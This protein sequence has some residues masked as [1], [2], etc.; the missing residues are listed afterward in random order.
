[1]MC[2]GPGREARYLVSKFSNNIDLC[3]KAGNLMQPEWNE[4]KRFLEK[5]PNLSSRIRG[6]FSCDMTQLKFGGDETHK[7]NIVH[8]GYAINYLDNAPAIDFLQ[9]MIPG[10]I[11]LKDSIMPGVVIVKETTKQKEDKD[12]FD[13]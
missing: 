2:A 6:M 13:T 3:D 4:T 7:Y 1:M 12:N 11:N 9:N 5:Q 10:L 8:C